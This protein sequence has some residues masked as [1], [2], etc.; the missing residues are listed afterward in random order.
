M[1][2]YFILVFATFTVGSTLLTKV[3]QAQTVETLTVP[4]NASGGVT[5]G[6]DGSIYVA[7]YGPTLSSSTGANVTRVSK[8]GSV[9]IF[10]SG[11]A[12]ASGNAFDSQ[13]NLYQSNIQQG[14]IMKIT[15]EGAV[16]TFSTGHQT[17]IGIAIDGDDNVFVA[18]CGG[19][20][21]QALPNRGSTIIATG[22]PLRCPNG[23]AIDP[24]GNLYTSN[25]N[26]GDVL[27]ITQAGV[28]TW[29]TTI[30]GT[31]NGHLTFANGRL[32]VVARR[33]NRIHEVML[34]GTS[35]ILAGSGSRGKRNG[36]ALQATF[37]IPNG[38]A[39]SVTGDTL[40]VNDAVPVT[41]D[42]FG[43]LN[44]VVVRMIVGVLGEMS[45]GNDAPELELP[46]ENLL[47]LNY[48]N[49]FNKRTTIS[50]DLARASRVVLTVY[51]VLGRQV[52]SLVNRMEE[53]GPH[54]VLFDATDLVPGTYFYKLSTD[55]NTE[56]RSMIRVE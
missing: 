32:Y 21:R 13:G 25:F 38:I 34:D 46:D 30:L 42:P 24:D 41:G 45:T 28:V 18:N 2:R 11:F 36:D 8:D 14:S 20:I 52:Q 15:P 48:P 5:R 31:N 55:T 39:A 49:P 35:R 27:K 53:T 22:L 19:H 43:V 54:H 23:L 40:Y 44:P 50:Y 16:S 9:E 33:G 10:A 47:R 3:S 56:V 26:N 51:D 1:Y 29:L 6:P 7:D 37:S 17:P 12:G 4:F